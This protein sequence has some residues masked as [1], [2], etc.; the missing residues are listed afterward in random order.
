M[1]EPPPCPTARSLAA[2][3]AAQETTAGA[4][5]LGCLDR[6]DA[7]EPTL[8]AWMIVDREG[9]LEQARGWDKARR[10]GDKLPALAGIPVAVKDNIETAY[11]NNW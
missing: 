10:L 2:A 6:I 3:F 11:F 8:G 5:L 7:R 9:A 4:A 1:S